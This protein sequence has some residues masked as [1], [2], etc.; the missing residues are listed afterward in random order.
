MICW[1]VNGAKKDKL[2]LI[3]PN[4]RDKHH[5]MQ[6]YN[7]LKQQSHSAWN[8]FTQQTSTTA[9]QINHMWKQLVIQEHAGPAA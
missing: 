7:I 4:K 2:Y 9:K 8:G 1:H 5:E 3:K 6:F